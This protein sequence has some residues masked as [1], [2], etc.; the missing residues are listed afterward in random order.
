[1]NRL[2]LVFNV[3]KLKPAP[4]DP[5]VGRRARPPP[6]PVLVD[7]EVEYEVERIMNSRFWYR[8]LQFLVAWKGYGRE[9]WSWVD[10]KDIHAPELIAEFYRKNS[11]TPRRI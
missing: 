5:I 11:G 2:H 9:E 10:E 7:G 8:K 4:L 3:V 1:M 6:D